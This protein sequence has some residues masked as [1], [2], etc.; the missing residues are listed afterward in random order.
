[1]KK[2]KKHYAGPVLYSDSFKH[3]PSRDVIIFIV[4]K[5][6][7]IAIRKLQHELKPKS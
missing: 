6:F 7:K 1:M 4:R 3:A 5:K 2:S